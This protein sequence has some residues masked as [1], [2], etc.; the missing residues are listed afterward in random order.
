MLRIRRFLDSLSD[1]KI[2]QALRVCKKLGLGESLQDVEE[3]DFQ[4]K[5]LLQLLTKPAAAA[6]LVYFLLLYLSANP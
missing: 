6:V 5:L 1:E 3:I 2:D 4:G